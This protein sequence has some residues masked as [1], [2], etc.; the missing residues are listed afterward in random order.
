[1]FRMKLRNKAIKWSRF[2]LFAFAACAGSVEVEW[3]G[4]VG[5][6]GCDFDPAVVCAQCNNGTVFVCECH[7]YNPSEDKF[8]AFDENDPCT[9]GK[10]SQLCGGQ[11]DFVEI[12]GQCKAPEEEKTP[13]EGYNAACGDWNPSSMIY[14]GGI[15]SYGVSGDLIAALTYDHTPLYACNSARIDVTA[16]FEVESAVSTDMVYLLGLRNGDVLVEINGM[17]LGDPFEA[18]MAYNELYLV[19]GE[20][21][22]TLKVQRGTGYVYLSYGILWTL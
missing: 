1:M 10:C 2:G 22:Y 19:Q 9:G 14:N 4:P 17:P 18:L 8:G 6:L 7:P 12:P 3:A 21:T 15:N 20:D 13:T 11:A 16:G 5:N